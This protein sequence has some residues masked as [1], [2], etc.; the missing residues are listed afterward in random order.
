MALSDGV[1]DV[2]PEV[3]LDNQLARLSS[4]AFTYRMDMDGLIRELDVYSDEK[5]NDDITIFSVERKGDN[6]F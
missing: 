1:L 6:G 2:L 4:L 5:Q 3:G